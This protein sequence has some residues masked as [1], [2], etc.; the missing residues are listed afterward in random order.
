M[1]ACSRDWNSPLLLHVG[2]VD[3]EYPRLLYWPHAPRST[4]L[5]SPRK[6]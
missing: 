6:P 1:D 4:D 5:E 2:S 3:Q